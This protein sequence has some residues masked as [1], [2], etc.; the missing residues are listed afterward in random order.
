M[1]KKAE[2]K[3]AKAPAKKAETK[4]TEAPA[5]KHLQKKWQQKKIILFY[6]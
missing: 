5:K 4:E 3:E 2:T 1:A 6:H